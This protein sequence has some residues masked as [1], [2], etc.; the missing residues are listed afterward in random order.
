MFLFY[1]LIIVTMGNIVSGSLFMGMGYWAASP[2]SFADSSEPAKKIQIILQGA[3]DLLLTV[4]EW[5][6]EVTLMA[7]DFVSKKS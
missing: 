2:K 7:I 1:N 6:K 3:F 4:Y 5:I